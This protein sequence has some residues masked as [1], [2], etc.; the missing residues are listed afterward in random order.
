[1]T[2]RYDR[3][4]PVLDRLITLAL[5]GP[6]L[7]PPEY[8]YGVPLLGPPTTVKVWARRYERP[9]AAVRTNEQR[10]ITFYSL[11]SGL[12]GLA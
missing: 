7:D 6:P 11:P 12:S 9:R 3:G 1:M 8:A 2:T 4:A 5:A 10:S